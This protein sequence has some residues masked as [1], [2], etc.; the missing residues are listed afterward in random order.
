MIK[1]LDKEGYLLDFTRTYH[2]MLMMTD[3]EK[4]R[5]FYWDGNVSAMSESRTC[6][7]PHIFHYYLQDGL[8][9]PLRVSGYKMDTDGKEDAGIP[10][11]YSRQGEE[12]PFA[13]T[14]YWYDRG[15]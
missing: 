14:G 3:V 7:I 6:E 5:I 8:G 10:N 15:L 11:P 1:K 12:Q 4:S 2:N 9:S 13:Y